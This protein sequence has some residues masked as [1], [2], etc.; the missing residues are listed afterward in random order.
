M[1]Y[2]VYLLCAEFSR[3]LLFKPYSNPM[4][5]TFAPLLLLLI[6]I[7]ITIICII[8]TLQKRKLKFREGKSLT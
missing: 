5:G 2:T 6:I 4:K 3:I 1:T 7:T 8:I